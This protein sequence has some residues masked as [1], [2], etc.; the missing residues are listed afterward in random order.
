MSKKGKSREED[1]TNLRSRSIDTSRS[2]R[3]SSRCRRSVGSDSS[4]VERVGRDVGDE[5]LS[6]EGEESFP[7]ARNH[8]KRRPEVSKGSERGIEMS[9]S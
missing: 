2:R 1:Q 9:R 7:E 5:L 3:P 8:K 6:G 4:V